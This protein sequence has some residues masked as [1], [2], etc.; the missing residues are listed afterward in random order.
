M[1]SLG[2]AL[3]LAACGGNLAPSPAAT[4]GPGATAAPPTATSIPVVS[5]PQA[6]AEK[7][8][9]AADAEARYQALLLV[10][11][12]LTIGVYEPA[13]GQPILRGM[14]RGPNDF[15][16]YDFELRALASALARGQTRDTTYLVDFFNAAGFGIDGN[17]VAT[18]TL[19]LALQAAVQTSAAAPA[20]PTSL[21]FLLV[22][23]LGLRHTT[24]YDMLQEVPPEQLQ[25]DALQTLLIEADVLVPVIRAEASS[26]ESKTRLLTTGARPQGLAAP[27]RQNPCANMAG[28]LSGISPFLKWAMGLVGGPGVLGRLRLDMIHGEMLAYSVQVSAVSEAQST[29]YGHESPGAEM[30]FQLKVEML[31]DYGDFLVNCGLLA[32]WEVPKK[33]PIPGIPILWMAGELEKHGDISYEPPDKKT[34]TSGI[35]TLVFKPK[36]EKRPRQGPVVEEKGTVDGVALYQSAFGNIPGSI[37]QFLVPKDALIAWTVARH[38]NLSLEINLSGTIEGSVGKWDLGTQQVLVPLEGDGTGGWKGYAETT[39]SAVLSGECSGTA[40]W[41]AS[42]DVAATGSDP[43]NFSISGS[44]LPQLTMQCDGGGGSVQLPALKGIKPFTFSLASQDGASFEAGEL[45]TFTFREQ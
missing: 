36:N 18:D 42:F 17:P 32:G 35:A 39:L 22:R 26:Q 15:Y 11:R 30:R 13:T 12:A 34:D 8:Y 29:H 3:M 23:E 16:L 43:L 10:M 44:F 6:L 27:A 28:G 2:L 45:W 7:V 14:E 21:L 5:N 41:P 25:F 19:Q 1:L 9:Q 20:D 38:K 40:T 4:A 37:A 31:D 24:P 33:G